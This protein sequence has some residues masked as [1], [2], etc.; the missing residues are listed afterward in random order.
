MIRRK[1]QHEE[2]DS[3]VAPNQVSSR[4]VNSEI[5]ETE[6]HID[7]MTVAVCWIQ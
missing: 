6:V 4:D 3:E 5:D 7:E 1:R 2:E